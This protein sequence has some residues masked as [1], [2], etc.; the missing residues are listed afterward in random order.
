MLSYRL[1]S[2]RVRTLSL[3]EH[4]ANMPEKLPPPITLAMVVCDAIWVDPT[5][6]KTSLLGLFSQF[7]A[8]TFPTTYPLICVHVCMTGAHGRIPLEL[9]LVDA[10]DENDPLVQVPEEVDFPNRGS[11][12]EWD[13]EM[14]NVEF[15]SP[16]DYCLQ[17]YAGAEFV[18][19]RRITVYQAED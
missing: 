1:V 8:G 3:I 11:M 7:G 12:I 19:E 14:E 4:G 2:S 6:G 16:G 13:V 18:L 17:L 5:G 9:R 10:D 15:P